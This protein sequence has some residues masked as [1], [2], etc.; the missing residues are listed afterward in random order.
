MDEYG[1]LVM[2]KTRNVWAKMWLPYARLPYVENLFEAVMAPHSVSPV[3]ADDLRKGI[4]SGQKKICDKALITY[5]DGTTEQVLPRNYVLY[6]E[7]SKKPVGRITEEEFLSQ[8][9]NPVNFCDSCKTALVNATSVQSHSF[10][11]TPKSNAPIR[12]LDDIKS[13][14]AAGKTINLVDDNGKN[15]PIKNMLELQNFVSAKGLNG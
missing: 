15:V 1:Q 9:I 12:N 2:R 8:F 11:P 7:T 4:L 13:I 10:S 3:T 6:H 14:F 5:E